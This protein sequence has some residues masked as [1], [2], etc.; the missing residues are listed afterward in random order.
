MRRPYLFG[1]K[2]ALVIGSSGG[3]GMALCNALLEGGWN[4][5][6]VSRR[7]D[8][9]DITNE[10]HIQ[11]LLHKLKPPYELVIVATGQLAPEGSR[12]E[13][14]LRELSAQQLAEQFAVNTIGPAM[15][16]AQSAKLLPRKRSSVIAVLSARV[17]SI[18]DNRLGGW[19]S[20][21]ASKAALNQ[22]VKSASIE[23]A[24]THPSAACVAIHPGT[25]ATRFTQDYLQNHKTVPPNVAAHN[26]LSVLDRLEPV[27]T[28][29]FFDWAGKSIP[30]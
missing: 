18:G 17:G 30:W 15:I 21:R 22:L 6:A 7:Q 5:D 23:L 1:M 14:S 2:N 20:Y 11:T 4:V 28:G 29:G 16:L 26:V 3:I 25:V 27:Q 10:T 19:Y 12:P 24:R 9:F 8:G 13:R